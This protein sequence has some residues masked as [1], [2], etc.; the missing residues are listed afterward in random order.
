M[1]KYFKKI[2]VLCLFLLL[3][4]L[5]AKFCHRA[6]DGFAVVN[7]YAPKGDHSKWDTPLSSEIKA[8]IDPILSGCFTYFSCGSQSYVFL[9]EDGKTVLKLFKFQH[10]RIPPWLESIP[11]PQ[12]IHRGRSQRRAQ[13]PC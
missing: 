4:F 11:L 9:S 10:L 7:V 6:T 8:E 12:K 2:I 3:G 5:T 13:A 1:R